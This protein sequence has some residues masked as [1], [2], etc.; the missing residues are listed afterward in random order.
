MNIRLIYDMPYTGWV[1]VYAG[2]STYKSV[3]VTPNMFRFFT[4]PVEVR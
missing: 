1:C 3:L 4:A 2:K